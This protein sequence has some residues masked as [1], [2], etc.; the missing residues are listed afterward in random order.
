[1][2][3]LLLPSDP[4]ALK[5]FLGLIADLAPHGIVPIGDYGSD[6]SWTF[7]FSE[8]NPRRAYVTLVDDACLYFNL[9]LGDRAY[10]CASEW[11]QRILWVE[12]LRAPSPTQPRTWA[13]LRCQDNV[14]HYDATRWP[15]NRRRMI[16]FLTTTPRKKGRLL[17]PDP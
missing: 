1:M 16:E 15:G 13:I 10:H 7:R 17:Q 14:D 12:R 8:F 11:Q 9:Y 5:A 6:R 4:Q 2:S 3:D